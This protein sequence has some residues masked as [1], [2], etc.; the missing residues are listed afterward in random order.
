MAGVCSS[1]TQGYGRCLQEDAG[2]W[3]EDARLWWVFAGKCKVVVGV[4]R[5][6]HSLSGCLQEDTELWRTCARKHSYSLQWPSVGI[7][8]YSRRHSYSLQWPSA[9]RQSYNTKHR[10][11]VAICSN[12]ELQHKHRVT[13]ASCSKTELQHKTQ[14]YNRHQQENRA[15]AQDTTVNTDICRKT[16]L[17]HKTQQLIQTSAG[18]QSYSTRHNS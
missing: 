16:E 1:K 14:S 5:K 15:T 8:S 3:Q 12:T 11:T 13:V 7:Q 6:T 17:Q 10:V 9:G 18:K 2:L 4:F